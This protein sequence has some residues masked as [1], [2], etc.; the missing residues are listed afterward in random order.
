MNWNEQCIISKHRSLQHNSLISCDKLERVVDS[1]IYTKKVTL[2]DK[3]EQ[4]VDSH[5]MNTIARIIS[6]KFSDEV[7][8][9]D[10]MSMDGIENSPVFEFFDSIMSCRD[11]LYLSEVDDVTVSSPTVDTR[12]DDSTSMSSFHRIVYCCSPTMSMSNNMMDKQDYYASRWQGH[13]PLSP[14]PL[15][16]SLS[17]NKMSLK[18]RRPVR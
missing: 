7:D 17:P 1:I 18:K 14:M 5:I 16:D 2:G 9:A 12:Q 11:G 6:D 8:P 13:L 3:L 15:N 4:S 10:S